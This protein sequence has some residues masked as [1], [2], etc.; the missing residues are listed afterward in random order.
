[1]AILVKICGINT[2]EAADAAVRAG[3]DFGGLVFHPRSPRHLTFE[4]A[5][6]LSGR[7]RGRLRLVALVADADDALIGAAIEAV[8]P[9]FL[10]LHGGES[11][12]RAAALKS[13]FQVAVIKA[14]PVADGG[15]LA[16]ARA[17]EP[18]ADM[19]LFDARAPDGAAR[20]GGHGAPF[21]WQL[22]RGRTFTRPWFLA[23]GLTPVNVAR[24]VAGA[25]ASAVD[26]S[27][28]VE[29]APGVKNPD[30]I[31]AF[32]SAARGSVEAPT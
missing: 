31:A 9:D 4:A 22:L 1:M 30:L 29:S 8:R 11:P 16:A 10:Q 3:A 28:G 19:L 26:V 18:V 14:V 32:V 20:P 25:D 21:D 7:L 13:R 17:F 27:S 15:D 2:V 12:A 24:A 5:R 23:G 6:A